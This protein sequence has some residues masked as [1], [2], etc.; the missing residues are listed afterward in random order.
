MKKK[1]LE[2]D[3]SYDFELLGISTVAKGFRLAWEFNGLLN[4]HLKK[5]D[6][7]T[8]IEGEVTNSYSYFVDE[9]AS[10]I[11]RLFKNKSNESD[12]IKYFLVPEHSHFDF[13]IMVQGE[14][15]DSKRLQKE[16]KAIPSIELVAFIPL[17][18]LKS[19]DHFIF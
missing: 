16:L 6:D 9:K 7:L 17:D 2:I 4:C 13:I 12:Q 18:S 11:L 15:L 3:Y 5:A 19:K 14:E 8:I 1:K 10:N